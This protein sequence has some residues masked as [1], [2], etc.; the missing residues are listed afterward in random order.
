MA[1]NDLLDKV[2][3]ELGRYDHSFFR[4]TAQPS[5][6]GVVLAIIIVLLNSR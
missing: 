6:L 3:K 1:E 4:F 2:E 5:E